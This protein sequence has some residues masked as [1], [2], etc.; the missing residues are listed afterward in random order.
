MRTRIL[1]I[2]VLCAF[3]SACQSIGHIQFLLPDMHRSELVE[4]LGRLASS[5]GLADRREQSLAPATIAYF[6]EGERSFTAIG[7][8]MHEGKVVVDLLFRSTGVGG[9]L[10]RQLKPKLTDELRKIYGEDFVIVEDPAK[11]AQQ[12]PPNTSFERTR[13]G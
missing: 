13:E 11:M 5:A 7:A 6:V 12:S 1:L 8:R 10:Y 4:A 2:A 3:L 9:D